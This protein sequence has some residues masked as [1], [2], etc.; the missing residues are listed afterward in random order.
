MFEC[1]TETRDMH[2]Q[3]SNTRSHNALFKVNFRNTRADIWRRATFIC[4]H[5]SASTW[6]ESERHS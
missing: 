6:D 4:F 2:E 5:V 1:T 3:V